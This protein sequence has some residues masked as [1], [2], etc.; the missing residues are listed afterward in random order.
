[1]N[2]KITYDWLLE[3][4]ETDASPYEIQKYLSLCGPSVEKVE[5]IDN[6]CVF[7]IEI[8]S[9]RIDM[10][11][12]Y[13]IA[14]EASAILPQFGKKAKLKKRVLKYPVIY[15]NPLLPIDI[16]D[17]S[18]L[19]N[20]VMAVVMDEV[21]IGE[22]P[23]YIRDRLAHAGIRSLNN[24]IDITNYVMLDTGHP[25][26][27]FDY[28][29]LINRKLIFRNSKKGDK[30]ITLED[31]EYEL[32][33][34]DSVIEDGNGLIVDLPGIIGL[35]NSIVTNNTKRIVYF[36]DNN[37]PVQMRQTS[38]KLG[39]RTLAVVYNEKGPDPNLTNIA[40]LRGIELY[41]KIACAKV[42]G[43]IYDLYPKKVKEKS[44]KVYLKDIQKAM[45]I[46][47]EERKVI[48]ILTNL[49]FG[50]NRF[51]DP[52][53]AYPDGVHMNISIPT[54][55]ANDVSIKEDIIEEVARVYG[56]HNLPNSLSPMVYIKQPKDIELL[57]KVQYRLKYLLKHMGLNEFMNY[58][59]I[60]KTQINDLNY[61]IESHLKISNSISQDIEYMRSTLLPSLIKNIKDNI[62][63]KN[64]LKIFEIAKVYKKKNGNLPKEE[65]KLALAVNSDFSD[66]TGIINAL[67]HELNIQKIGYIP[68]K[69]EKFTN[70]AQITIAGKP[71][72]NIGKLNQKYENK[73]NITTPVYLAELSVNDLTQNFHPYR[74][75]T[76][77]SKYAVV[78][79]DLTIVKTITYNEIV[80]V[81]FKKSKLLQ[82]VEFIGTYKDNISLRFFFGSNSENINESQAIE[83]LG[84]IKKALVSN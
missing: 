81:A 54:H 1:M 12:V 44:I 8:T 37:N 64:I 20:R 29:R 60:S 50:V 82:K 14:Q 17:K 62:G 35:K 67:F 57:Y 59:M 53:L 75:Y 23:K 80:E 24:V 77:P 6:T 83:E 21:K 38:M 43:K 5:K 52:E 11:S 45:G 33:G 84:K 47:I 4:L 69:N 63:K 34:N 18:E 55:R 41:E 22:S 31:K 2:I 27:V 40:L 7:D 9:N 71:I 19:T 76:S 70:A 15:N 72:G 48:D 25:A 66:L 51:E 56:Y 61:D 74:S 68:E 28:D 46:T 26:H 49:G 79:L 78:K 30:I 3:Y 16:S 32:F 10:A 36:L 65:Y 42:I 58:S 73:L 39:I 13:G